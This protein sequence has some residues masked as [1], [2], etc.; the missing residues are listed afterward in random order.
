M[1]NPPDPEEWEATLAALE[2]QGGVQMLDEACGCCR[3]D[4][5]IGFEMLD[6][7]G[8][9][10]EPQVF[11]CIVCDAMHLWPRINDWSEN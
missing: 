3:T 7:L 2:G 4:P 1:F 8:D 11:S 6:W 10:K 9:E 5:V